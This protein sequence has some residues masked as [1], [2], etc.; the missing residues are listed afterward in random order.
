MHTCC[1]PATNY[2]AA[3]ARASAAVSALETPAGHKE[4][5]EQSL[6]VMHCQHMLWS[7][8]QLRSCISSG[9]C[10]CVSFRDSYRTQRAVRTQVCIVNTC[11]GPA[12]NCVAASARVSA[13]VSACRLLQR[14][15]KKATC[16]FWGITSLCF[17]LTK[18]GQSSGCSPELLRSCQT[19]LGAASLLAC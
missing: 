12:P 13:A 4:L 7:C 11:C 17:D 15:A 2:A 6:M 9:F 14:C 5:S 8:I 16:R 18:E 10:C 19:W 1:G 3:S